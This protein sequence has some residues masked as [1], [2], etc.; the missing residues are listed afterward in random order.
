MKF[1]TALFAV[2]APARFVSALQE[3]SSSTAIYD[4]NIESSALKAPEV[5]SAV[6]LVL[7]A[8]DAIPEDVLLA[9]DEAANDW[10]VAHGYRSAVP[11]D[12]G[13]VSS[14]SDLVLS[15]RAIAEPAGT[16]EVLK[17]VAEVT[18]FIAS[19][20]LPVAKLLKIK[21]AIKVIGSIKKVAQLL[22][23]ITSVND[24]KS[25]GGDALYDIAD[26]IFGFS[27][28]WKACAKV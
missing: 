13:I 24:A 14:R 28:V 17:C 8:I 26:A 12:S 18:K 15:E 20:A 27:A 2:L 22:S 10:L 16:I 11:A 25:V 3:S 23:K 19:N 1:T 21:K 5:L 9:G 7:E 4:V 6:E